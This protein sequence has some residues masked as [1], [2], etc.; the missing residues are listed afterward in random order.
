MK[1]IVKPISEKEN[2][3]YRI[4]AQDGDILYKAKKTKQS[5]AGNLERMSK[6]AESRNSAEIFSDVYYIYNKEDLN[7]MVEKV[8]AG[9]FTFKNV[10][11]KADINLSGSNFTPIVATG[12]QPELNING[13]D[14]IIYGM[15]IRTAADVR[16]STSYGGGFLARYDGKYFIKNIVFDHAD[17]AITQKAID[18]QQ[19]FTKSGNCL[20]VVAGYA[21]SGAVFENVSVI[22]SVVRGYGKVAGIVG[23]S[24]PEKKIVFRGCT[25]ANNTL[26]AA[27]NV[28]PL[29]G[30]LHRGLKKEFTNVEIVNCNVN[31]NQWISDPSS[32]YEDLDTKVSGTPASLPADYPVKGKYMIMSN[33]YYMAAF[34]PNYVSFGSSNED[35]DLVGTDKK[36]CNGEIIF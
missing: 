16:S 11:I 28:A 33:Q 26:R 2:T 14:H 7:Q 20:A 30:C 10:E 29:G 32:Q 18:D 21:I 23:L 25:V 17:V 22:N 31:D 5:Q 34:A 4:Y 35:C 3:K 8:N 12:S 1:T 19:E 13:N 6:V 15:T 24:N 9:Q 27:T 36:L